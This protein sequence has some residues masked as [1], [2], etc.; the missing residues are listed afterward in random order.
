M[1][2]KSLYALAVLTCGLVLSPTLANEKKAEKDQQFKID[3]LNITAD[4]LEADLFNNSFLLEGNVYSEGDIVSDKEMKAKDGKMILSADR[5]IIKLNDNRKPETLEAVGNVVFCCRYTQ[6]TGNF[7]NIA[8]R[9]GHAVYNI[10]EETLTVTQK[11]EISRGEMRTYGM[12]KLVFNRKTGKIS[13][14]GTR[15][16]IGKVLFENIRPGEIEALIQNLEEKKSTEPA[17]KP[18]TPETPKK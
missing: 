12:E 9:G 5:M 16:E 18:A 1:K 7:D 2:I 15:P 14:E 11:P 4:K 17:E 8:I 13:T 3:N 6:P 10:A